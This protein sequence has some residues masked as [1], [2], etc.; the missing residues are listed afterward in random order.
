M[1][2]V[3]KFIF[4][5]EGT[6]AVELRLEGYQ[7]VTLQLSNS[8]DDSPKKIHLQPLTPSKGGTVKGGQKKGKGK[9]KG[10]T[11]DNNDLDMLK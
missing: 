6:T 3:R 4:E 8:A 11:R 9:K 1:G 2:S 5:T 7:P 10:P